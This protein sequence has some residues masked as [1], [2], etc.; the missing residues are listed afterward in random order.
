MTN[1]VHNTLRIRL[2]DGAAQKE[3][4]EFLDG[5]QRQNVSWLFKRPVV[6]EPAQA[7]P[8]DPELDEDRTPV[9]WHDDRNVYIDRIGP[10]GVDL[11]FDSRW[12]P[13]AAWFLRIHKCYPS[14]RLRLEFREEFHAHPSFIQW[15]GK[16]WT[17]NYDDMDIQDPAAGLESDPKCQPAED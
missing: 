12:I 3:L 4:R 15:D 14:W 5:T 13:P 8:F 10:R 2:P 6:S 11:L 7:P 9:F 17:E 1:W 16:E